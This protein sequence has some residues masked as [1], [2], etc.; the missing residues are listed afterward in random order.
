MAAAEKSET[1][2]I[3]G[4]EK[5]PIKAPS[6]DLNVAACAKRE[7]QEEAGISELEPEF[8]MEQSNY[9]DTNPDLHSINLSY[10]FHDSSKNLPPETKA[11]SDIG[12]LQW[13][14]FSDIEVKLAGTQLNYSFRGETI[15]RDHGPILEKGAEVLVDK[16]IQKQSLGLLTLATLEKHLATQASKAKKPLSAIGCTKPG[17]YL[18]S[19]AALYYSKLEKLAAAYTSCLEQGAPFNFARMEAC[20]LDKKAKQTKRLATWCSLFTVAA[21]A[22]VLAYKLYEATNTPRPK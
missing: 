5:T 16:Q 17:S 19:E 13:V 10:L 14:K 4:L 22:G 9:P 18:G 3:P 11:G 2:F 1:R 20:L 7:L 12:K 6:F 21:G 8:L 15:R